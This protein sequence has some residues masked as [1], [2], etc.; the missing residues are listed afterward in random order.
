MKLLLKS[1]AIL[2]GLMAASVVGITSAI[3]SEQD[4]E[5]R[6]WVEPIPEEFIDRF[7]SRDKD[8]YRN[9]SIPRQAS[10]LFGF[11]PSFVELEMDADGKALNEFTHYMMQRQANSGP[12]IRTPDLIN[13]YQ[14]SLLS[15]PSDQTG[16]RPV[17]G[18]E[19]VFESLPAR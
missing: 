9:R 1:S 19:L 18:S 13:P 14:D 11:P 4:E 10:S 17:R 7:F 5:D 12:I 3:A 8:Y 6:I 15:Y 16:V 2:F